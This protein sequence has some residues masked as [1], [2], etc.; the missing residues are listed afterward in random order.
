MSVGRKAAPCHERGSTGNGNTKRQQPLRKTRPVPSSP[1]AAIHCSRVYMY[2]WSSFTGVD[3]ERGRVRLLY[4]MYLIGCDMHM[5]SRSGTGYSV[6]L[7]D[8][9]VDSDGH[10]CLLWMS[11]HSRALRTPPRPASPAQAYGTVG[12]RNANRPCCMYAMTEADVIGYL[13]VRAPQ[14]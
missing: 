8:T 3:G 13:S 12:S 6:R 1:T 4:A 7:R 14:R 9:R 5:A 11:A 2:R 10:W